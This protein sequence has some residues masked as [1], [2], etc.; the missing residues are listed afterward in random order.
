MARLKFIDSKRRTT[1]F[2]IMRFIRT[3]RK[4]AWSY[5]IN[6]L[7]LISPYFASAYH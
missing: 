2:L 6:T 4:A 1:I 5:L 7:M 3:A